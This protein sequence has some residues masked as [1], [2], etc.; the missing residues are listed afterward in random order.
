MTV[1]SSPRSLNQAAL[2]Q[3]TLSTLAGKWTMS[4]LA[5]LRRADA[6][7]RSELQQQ[8]PDFDGKL[9]KRIVM[10]EINGLI[11]RT[12]VPETPRGAYTIHLTPAGHAT[13]ALHRAAV[14]WG[15]KHLKLSDEASS[16]LLAE[17]TLFRLRHPHATA[18][19][20]ELENG[21]AFP[22]EVYGVLPRGISQSAIYPLLKLLVCDGMLAK[23]GGPARWQYELT[24]AAR[25]LGSVFQAV[26]Q[27][28]RAH[29]TPPE[30]AGTSRATPKPAAFSSPL[31]APARL[32]A[33]G[34]GP[35]AGLT[36]SH[37]HKPV[38]TRTPVLSGSRG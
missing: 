11:T 29:R 15:A 34:R 9:H 13:D 28:N 17:Q 18:L 35:A 5:C 37:S 23:T 1:I 16:T 27:W 21:P 32:P 6:I 38:T 2:V 22:S 31:A 20:W 12:L 24:D 8:L 30:V 14:Q 36:F 19:I 26:S 25:D 33:A 3:D 10:M 7:T 4:S